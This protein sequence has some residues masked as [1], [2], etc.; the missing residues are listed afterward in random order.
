MHGSRKA[1]LRLPNARLNTECTGVAFGKGNSSGLQSREATPT[2]AP[3]MDMRRPSVWVSLATDDALARDQAREQA[4]AQL[5]SITG[6]MFQVYTHLYEEER[7]ELSGYDVVKAQTPTSFVAS[8]A[9]KLRRAWER[10]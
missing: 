7:Q 1:R 8:C 5:E 4:K 10:G 9:V 3:P 6:R 2:P